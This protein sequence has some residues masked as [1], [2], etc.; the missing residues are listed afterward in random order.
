MY[1]YAVLHTHQ[2]YVLFYEFMKVPIGDGEARQELLKENPDMETARQGFLEGRNHP[3]DVDGMIKLVMR[4]NNISYIERAIAIWG[5]AEAI[6]MQLMPIAEDLRKEI[7]NE[8]L[9]QYNI[10]TLRANIYEINAKLTHLEDAFSYT[11][12]EGS[13]WFEG[14]VFR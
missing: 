4:F 11:L 6:A 14:N 2:D 9:S 8:N 3:D 13:R 10:E 1:R 7:E 12:G 5:E